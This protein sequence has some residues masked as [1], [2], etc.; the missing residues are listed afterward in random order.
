MNEAR[1]PVQIFFVR[2]LWFWFNYL[3][4]SK[5]K[6]KPSNHS[7][8]QNYCCLFRRVWGSSE[9]GGT[10]MG[11]NRMHP[12]LKTKSVTNQSDTY[13]KLKSWCTISECSTCNIH[14]IQTRKSVWDITQ[15]GFF[16]GR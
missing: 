7:P 6:R 3:G 1:N 11:S 14:R 9:E 16:S 10:F 12:V 4:G 15:K 13:T 8:T 5:E 2:L